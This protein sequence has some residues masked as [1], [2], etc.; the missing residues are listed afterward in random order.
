[1]EF[2]HAREMHGCDACGI[3]PA[4]KIQYIRDQKVWDGVT[5]FTDRCIPYVDQVQSPV[6]VA[7]IIEPPVIR[8]QWYQNHTFLEEKFDYILTYDQR[9]IES[10]PN[11]YIRYHLS[12]VRI[13][14]PDRAIYDKTKLT[15]LVLSS[16]KEA[17]GHR[18]RH[19][20]AEKFG[21]SMD[22]YGDKYIPY[23]DCLMGYKDYAFVIVTMNC[24]MD[25]FFAEYLTHAFVTGAV[26]V[27]WGCPG[28]GE[29]FNSKGIIEFD[30]LEDLE[31][32]LPTLT[33]EL[34]ESMKPYV[35]DNFERAKNYI[36]AD[37]S[38]A[39]GITHLVNKFAIIS[40]VTN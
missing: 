19:D 12:S 38:V 9:L 37:D 32:I 14:K 20:I 33:F 25:Y 15:S 5:L 22:V 8:D 30:T 28:I 39:D 7:W 26:P 10:N 4:S 29:I 17:V 21:S 40:G 1:M 11:K 3:L 23:P 35:L 27:F 13:P 2:A 31:K 36:S 24:K 18:L 6:K 16:K 34:Y